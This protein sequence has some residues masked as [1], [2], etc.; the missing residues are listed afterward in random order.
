VNTF[1]Q[2][3]KVSFLREKGEGHFV[4]YINKKT[5]VVFHNDYGFEID[6][7]VEELIGLSP[8]DSVAADLT[9][10]DDSPENESYPV[11]VF[12]FMN[13]AGKALVGLYNSS[14]YQAYAELFFCLPP[15]VK[16]MKSIVLQPGMTSVLPESLTA[17]DALEVYL[18]VLF[19][20]TQEILPVKPYFNRL[21]LK[22]SRLFKQENY[23]TVK[24]YGKP[25]LLYKPRVEKP[26]T[27]PSAVKEATGEIEKKV[28]KPNAP[29]AY[30]EIDLHFHV[31]FPDINAKAVNNKLQ[32]QL[33]EARKR[34]DKAMLENY[35]GIILIHGVGEMVLKNA[36]LKLLE[37]Y[38]L[39]EVSDAPMAVYGYGAT[40]VIF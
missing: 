16:L 34:I 11:K 8:A 32:L 29:K 31:L 36:L 12:T 37:E 19:S 15:R 28:S 9:F 3:D 1:R 2:G 22:A 4:R 7:S 23:Q 14:A 5:A 25:I 20:S 39:R 33:E 27:P 17:S 21:A 26:I 10:E 38:S 35:Q 24:W 40:R 13:D 30:D 6:Y 18:Q